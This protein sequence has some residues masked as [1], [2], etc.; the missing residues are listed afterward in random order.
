[1]RNLLSLM[2]NLGP[3]PLCGTFLRNLYVKL[4]S[5]TFMTNLFPKR[6]CGTFLWNLGTCICG[7]WELVRV[8]PLL[9]TGSDGLSAVTGMLR[10]HTGEPSKRN[11]ERSQDPKQRQRRTPKEPSALSTEPRRCSKEPKA[12][13]HSLQGVGSPTSSAGTQGTT[14]RSN[15][16]AQRCRSINRHHSSRSIIASKH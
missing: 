10:C 5:G 14:E 6:L 9:H 12:R 16:S 1:M 3:K 4:L 13:E 8:E 2:W 15:V 7:T 11:G